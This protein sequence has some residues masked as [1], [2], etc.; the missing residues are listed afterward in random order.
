MLLTRLDIDF[1]STWETVRGCDPFL[2]IFAFISYYL[3]F[4]LRG[5]RWGMLLRNAG[6]DSDDGVDLPS[7]RHLTGMIVINWFVNSILYARVGDVYRAYILR[8]DVG[9]SFPKAV[10]TVV[11]ER[12]IDVVLIFC[13]IAISAL[14]LW[15]GQTTRSINI[16]MWIGLGL[17]LLV[18][19]L[20]VVM[21]VFRS[22]L[23]QHLPSR[24]R[25]IYGLF[26][27]GT[28][29]SFR[30]LPVLVVLSLGV[31]GLEVGR[32]FFVTQALGIE[33]SWPLPFLIL[34]AALAAALL[35]ALPLTPGGLGFVEVGLVGLLGLVFLSHDALSIVIVDRTITFVSVIIIGLIFFIVRQLRRR[36]VPAGG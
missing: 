5:I 2:Y 35:A 32:L 29:G 21:W 25:S 30:Q 24:L 8:E 12:A 15:H 6:F 16:I 4:P 31:W 13:L 36:R 11:A 17:V 34:F 27:E 20:L 7:V 18:V 9:A 23:E 14:V 22:R 10:G 19:C 28:F 33:L 1:A 26:H 3:A